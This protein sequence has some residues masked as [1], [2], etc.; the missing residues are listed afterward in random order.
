MNNGSAIG[1]VETSSIAKGFEI[2]DT[3]LKTANVRLVVNRTIC[4]G[5][6][7][8][9]IGGDVDVVSPPFDP[10]GTTALVGATILYE[11]ACVLADAYVSS[12][13]AS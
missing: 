12:R 6:Y 13:E 7:M 3:M 4:P 1:I 2:A 11:I 5:K 10:T 9:L 8:V